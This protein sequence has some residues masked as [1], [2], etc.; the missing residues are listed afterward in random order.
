MSIQRPVDFKKMCSSVDLLIFCRFFS[1]HF[2]RTFLIS[3]SSRFLS[4]DVSMILFDSETDFNSN[5]LQ[6][7]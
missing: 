2:F 5:L 6:M 4:Q 7:S 1:E 3:F